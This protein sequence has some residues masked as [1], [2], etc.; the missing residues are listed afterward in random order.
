M[1]GLTALALGLALQAAP[2]AG[3]AGQAPEV[4]VEGVR[5]S[6]KQIRD[7]VGALT[8]TPVQGQLS[9]FHLGVCPAVVGASAATSAAIAAR[10]R[11]VAQAAGMKAAPAG[12]KPNAL[13]LIA[14]DKRDLIERLYKQYP[15][16]F[17]GIDAREVRRLA[18]QPT[19]AAAWHVEGLL[20]RDG[21][22]VSRDLLSGYHVNESTGSPSRLAPPTRPHFVA[23]VLVVELQALAGLT[24]TQVAD[25][26]AMRTFA[27]ADPA[28]L[29][30]MSAPT[31]LTVID[32]P[33]DSAVPVTLTAWD[34]GFL[35]ALYQS[36]A[37]RFANQQ[38]GEIHTLVRRDLQRT[39]GEPDPAPRR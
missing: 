33:M 34:L 13:V 7:F 31:I 23:S 37:D 22:E 5:N 26:A 11:R 3:D 6:D 10:M 36:S 25:Y 39:R 32:A 29:G 38:R 35:N 21:L 9:R 14:R 20:D 8:K 24:T 12:C 27:R 28:H 17:T 2:P 30:N 1:I 19:R 16:Y 15:D 18:T 4:V